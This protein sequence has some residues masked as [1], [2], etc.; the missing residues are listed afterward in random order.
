MIDALTSRV[1]PRWP[2]LAAFLPP[3]GHVYAGA[4]L[5]G[6]VTA[7][8]RV[9]VTLFVG[10]LVVRSEHRGVVLALQ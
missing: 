2:W 8:P 10:T 6:S 7:G 9:A 4:P 5:R 3:L 1:K